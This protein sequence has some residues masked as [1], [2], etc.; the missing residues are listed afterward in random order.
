MDILKRHEAFEIEV[1]ERLKNGNFLKSLVF[2]GGTMLRLCHELNRYS[3]DLD[4]WFIKKVEPKAYFQRLKEYL[5]KYYEITDSQIKFNTILFEMRL[6]LYP[7]RLKI[8]IRRE[9]KKCDFEERIAFSRFG[10]KQVILRVHTLIQVM[11]NKIE[12]ALTR[13][14]IRDFFDIE[15]LLRRGA[16]LDVSADKLLALRKVA[17]AFKENDY[18]VS[19]GSLLDNSERAYYIQNKFEYLLTKINTVLT[20]L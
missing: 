16:A 7:K 3:A 20:S 8:E 19:L 1:L 9:V 14:D 15:F 11:N 4:F 10:T 2:T 13:K 5:S 18:R 12:A 6:P 17:I